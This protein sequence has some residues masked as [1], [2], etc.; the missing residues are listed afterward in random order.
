MGASRCVRGFSMTSQQR[1]AAAATFAR[2][3]MLACA[4]GSDMVQPAST[5]T[6]QRVMGVLMFMDAEQV[7]VA[8]NRDR[9]FKIEAAPDGIGPFDNSANA[10]EITTDNI[11]EICWVVNATTVALTNGGG[12]RSPAGYIRDVDANGKVYIDFTKFEELAT[13]RLNGLIGGP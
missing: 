9:Q 2:G 13:M 11:D 4:D 3:D 12:T 10:D 6:D 1:D 5:A 7:V 8:N